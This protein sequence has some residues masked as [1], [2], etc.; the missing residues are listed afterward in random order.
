LLSDD[1]DKRPFKDF[2]RRTLDDDQAFRRGL[3]DL[4]QKMGQANLGD[5]WTFAFEDKVAYF[6]GSL[7]ADTQ[8]YELAKAERGELLVAAEHEWKDVE[9]A[10]F[11]TLLEQALTIAQRTHLGAHYT[12]RL[13]VERIIEAT[14]TD[15]L[16][17]EWEELEADLE[18]RPVENRLTRLRDFH[19]RLAGIIVLDPACGT[20]NFL[21][22]AMEA[23]L[24]V[25]NKVIQAIEDLGGEVRSRIGPSQ[26]HGLEKNP[27]AA[28]IA[29]LVLWIGWLRWTI[30]NGAGAVEEP[31]LG[32]RANINFG[33]PGGYDAVLVQDETTAPDLANPRQPDWPE[34]D[35]IVGNPPFIG[36]KGIRSELGGDY[37]EALWKANPN[38]PASA[39]FVMQWWDRAARELTKPATRLRRFGFVTTNSITQV[40]SRRVIERH[41]DDCHLVLACPDHPWTKATRDAAAVRIAMTVAAGGPGEGRLIE[42][43]HEAGLNTDTPEIRFSEAYGVINANLSIGPDPSITVPLLANFGLSSRGMMLFGA[44]FIVSPAEAHALGLGKREGLEQHIRPYRNG[45]DLLQK[46]RNKM[47]I[48][49][50]PLSEEEARQ[51]FPEAYQHLLRTIKPERDR[52]RDR[53]LRD[54]W[55]QF[56]RPRTE[57]RP[58]LAELQRYIATV[59]TAKH[60]P[61][62]F[63]DAEI[64]PDNRIVCIALND[65][66]SLG[67]LSSRTHV[68]WS[69][70]AGGTLEDRPIYT[71][72]RIFDPSP[73]PMPRPS[74]EPPSPPLPRN[75]TPPAR[76]RSPKC[77]T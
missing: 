74:S 31:I 8:V 55:W 56:G 48:D 71:K 41:S 73:S 12:P 1:P 62:E 64:I 51:R 58:A 65:G 21:Y 36:G 11:G 49:L 50:F 33:R 38:V 75:S 27:R 18:G 60:R 22:V 20:G 7:F 32:Q 68:V 76:Q 15:V 19:E 53:D 3:A 66:F 77:R 6:N 26:F 29:E 10:I 54:R 70:R 59:E 63:L 42:V 4:W 13:H 46:S 39:D 35:F 67:V 14:I 28:K 69:R 2:L 9:P 72:S 17:A 52:N 61:F 5:R 44:G 40:F 23:L 57:I 25:E 47:V 45:R 16:R 34:A 30:R 43:E 37:A 24:G